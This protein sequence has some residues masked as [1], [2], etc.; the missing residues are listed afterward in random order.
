MAPEPRRINRREIEVRR[1]T[2]K[3]SVE[4]YLLQFEL[5]ARYNYCTDQEKISSLLCTL[6]GPVLAEIDNITSVSYHEVRWSLLARFGPSD[7]PAVHGQA[8]QQLRL[9]PGQNV[10]KLSQEVQRLT[11]RAYVDLTGGTGNQLIVG[12][13]L[14]AI[15][16]TDAVLYIRD[17]EP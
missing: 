5:A 14:R 9:N 10:R 7:L 2:G 6:D 12:F 16:D 8:L 17:K 11:R 4:D 1:Y 3:D 13:L 15:S